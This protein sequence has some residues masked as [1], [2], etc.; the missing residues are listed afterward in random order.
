MKY[1][2]YYDNIN[3]V[4]NFKSNEIIRKKKQKIFFNLDRLKML[5]YKKNKSNYN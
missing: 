4:K 3:M 5:R 2:K 1:N